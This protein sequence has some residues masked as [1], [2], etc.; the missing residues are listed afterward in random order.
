MMSGPP[1][2]SP[3]GSR[4]HLIASLAHGSDPAQVPLNQP[5]RA[6]FHGD[7]D[8]LCLLR[9]SAKVRG[10]VQG[11]VTFGYGSHGGLSPG[12]PPTNVEVSTAYLIGIRNKTPRPLDYLKSFLF[13]LMQHVC[14]LTVC[15]T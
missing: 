7:D 13:S 12:G 8:R 11:A 6:D 5:Q 4:N 10:R 1:G 15:E 2:D 3:R 9:L 14:R